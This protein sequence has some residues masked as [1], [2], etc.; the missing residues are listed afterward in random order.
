MKSS[1]KNPKDARV[2]RT[3]DRLGDALIQL[4]EQKPFE[5]ITVQEVLDRAGVSRATFYTHYTNKEDLFL[6]DVNDFWEYMAT[7]LERTGESSERVAAVRELFAHVSGA[8]QLRAALLAA[9][10][11]HDVLELGREHF[12]RGIEQRLTRLQRPE[13]ATV[14]RRA[15]LAQMFSGALF[16]LLDR[17]LTGAMKDTPEELDDF[18]HEMVWAVCGRRPHSS[19]RVAPEIS[20]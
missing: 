4:I 15:T 10:K 2:K 13:G 18:F 6:E 9:G 3:R 7:M 12:A 17:W 5:Q 14:Q 20:G 16:S 8:Q 1:A 19:Q 11:V